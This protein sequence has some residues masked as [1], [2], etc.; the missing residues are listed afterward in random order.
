ML[1]VKSLSWSRKSLCRRTVV[2]EKTIALKLS[3]ARPHDLTVI[4]QGVQ[5][6][7]IVPWPAFNGVKTGVACRTRVIITYWYK[8]SFQGQVQSIQKDSKWNIWIT[9]HLLARRYFYF[10]NLRS[11]CIFTRAD[12][13]VG[14]TRE[15]R[16]PFLLEILY[17]FYRIRRK[18]QGDK[19]ASV[20]ANPFWI[21]WFRP[22]FRLT[23]KGCLKEANIKRL[24]WRLGVS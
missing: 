10:T 15:P 14:R 23:K 9:P 1:G 8:Y 22:W 11:R 5:D 2:S 16:P 4:H 19:W 6:Q 21:F 12:L 7:H 24:S 13:V 17:Y 3:T 20:P 18:I